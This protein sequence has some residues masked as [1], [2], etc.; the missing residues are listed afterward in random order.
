VAARLRRALGQER[1]EAPDAGAQPPR[2]WPTP[3]PARLL[4]RRD[5]IESLSALAQLGARTD[6]S[7]ASSGVQGI[8][9]GAGKQELAGGPRGNAPRPDGRPHV[10]PIAAG[11]TLR[12][13]W[14]RSSSGRLPLRGGVMSGHWAPAPKPACT[15]VL[16]GGRRGTSA[17]SSGNQV[18][19][20]QSRYSVLCSDFAVRRADLVKWRDGAHRFVQTFRSE[21]ASYLGCP[22]H[23]KDIDGRRMPVVSLAKLDSSGGILPLS[24]ERLGEGET[25]ILND[26]AEWLFALQIYLSNY[27]DEA[28][29]QPFVCQCRFTINDTTVR[30]WVGNQEEIFTI[31]LE[32]PTS[33]EPGF[34]ALYNHFRAYL[35]LR[36]GTGTRKQ[37][38]GFATKDDIYPAGRP[39]L[40]PDRGSP[41]AL[42][43]RQ[44][45]AGTLPPLSSAR[46][47]APQESHPARV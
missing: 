4:R 40:C 20:E 23:F 32:N 9:S 25:T 16:V 13:A 39:A 44:R 1:D 37:R 5:I 7:R 2:S 21:F 22:E 24:I 3:A 19:M 45:R 14:G 28:L 17:A 11:R 41:L 30:L 33:L 18:R 47:S 29:K 34:D 8:N 36:P 27:E 26:D 35:R 12:C 42:S 43:Y 6:R 31:D 46:T 10:T 38:M 15:P